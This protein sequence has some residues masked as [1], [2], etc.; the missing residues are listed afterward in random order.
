MKILKIF[1]K[2]SKIKMAT[3]E[4]SRCGKRYGIPYQDAEKRKMCWD[5]S[6]MGKG[7]KAEAKRLGMTYGKYYYRVIN[8]LPLDAP[9]PGRIIKTYPWKGEMLTMKEIQEKTGLS[10]TGIYNQLKK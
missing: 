3:V 5:C 10:R 1:Y 2:P 8:N 6:R 9:L 7:Y 4:C